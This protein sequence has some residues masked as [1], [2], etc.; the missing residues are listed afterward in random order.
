[1]RSSSYEVIFLWGCLPRRSS[2]YKVVFIWHPSLA[3]CGMGMVWY[4]HWPYISSFDTFPGV[5]NNHDEDFPNDVNIFLSGNNVSSVSSH[6]KLGEKNPSTCNRAKYC[7]GWGEYCLVGLVWW[8]LGKKEDK[9]PRPALYKIKENQKKQE[10][11]MA[12]I[13]KKYP[14]QEYPLQQ[15]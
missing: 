1:M 14:Q 9:F 6:A 7:R 4:A 10:S 13:Q 15:K 11:K 2:S 5:G 12:F 8:W 3:W